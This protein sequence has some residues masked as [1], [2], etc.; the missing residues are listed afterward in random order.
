MSDSKYKS[1]KKIKTPDGDETVVYEYS[2]RQV[3][4]RHKEK[5]DR[6]DSLRE[7]HSELMK[8][9]SKDL[10]SKDMHTRMTALAIALI[11]ATYERVGNAESAKSGHYGVTGWLKKHMTFAK[12]KVIFRYTGKSGVRQEK[13]VH[14]PDI[15]RILRECCKGK[16]DDT[17]IFDLGEVG[18][19]TSKDV[20]AYLEDYEIT[21]K[22]LRGYHAN[23]EMQDRLRQIRKKGP[24][25]P[26]SRKEKDEI[27]G[28]EFK[29]ALEDVADV[30]GHEPATLR[31]QYLVPWMEEAYLHDGTVIESL[32]KEASM[33]I[34]SFRKEAGHGGIFIRV[35]SHLAH[36]FPYKEADTSPPHV[37]ICVFNDDYRHRSHELI[38]IVKACA[39]VTPEFTLAFNGT[40]CFRTPRNVVVF[41]RIDASPV[42]QKMFELITSVLTL[43][44][45]DWVDHGKFTPHT[46]LEYRSPGESPVWYGFPPTGS[47]DVDALEI[48][49]I[50]PDPVV[51]PFHPHKTATKTV[52]QREEEEAKRLIRREPKK[53]P[54]RKDLHRNTVRV[55]EDNDPDKKQDSK[56]RSHNFK[57]NG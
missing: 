26:H 28:E 2:E 7:V 12:N 53:K 45:F 51:I 41:S 40:S 57:D 56:D 34:A 42:L 15:L 18:K 23:R 11:D 50:A 25:L 32:C 16:S 17:P 22:D 8:R 37:T 43:K 21:A 5:A 6:I 35:P 46:T 10:E 39:E 55:D 9:V 33:K 38:S 14:D 48:W 36:Q 49:G 52:S 24:N 4:N 13:V 30:V 1:K 27:L 47:W 44:G 20:N 31:G 19:V 29:Q 54:P 3:L